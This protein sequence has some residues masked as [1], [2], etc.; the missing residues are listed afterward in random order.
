MD[1]ANTR[2]CTHEGK[3]AL[4]IKEAEVDTTMWMEK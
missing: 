1:V 4:L 2:K 3:S